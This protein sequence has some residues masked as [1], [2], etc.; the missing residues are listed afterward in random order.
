LRDGASAKN[1]NDDNLMIFEFNRSNENEESAEAHIH[2]FPKK[3]K[4]AR[5][6]RSRSSDATFIPE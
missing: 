2:E 4:T 3:A 6:G 5:K 1:S